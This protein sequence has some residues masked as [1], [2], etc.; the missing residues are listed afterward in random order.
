MIASEHAARQAADEARSRL[1][2]WEAE[3]VAAFRLNR[4]NHANFPHTR[5]QGKRAESS[6]GEGREGDQERRG[7]LE[8][9]RGESRGAFR[10]IELGKR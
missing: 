3:Y 2:A 1:E 4:I 5:S 10:F 6:F 7:A 8:G 9:C